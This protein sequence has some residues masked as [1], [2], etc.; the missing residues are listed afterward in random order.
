MYCE[1]RRGSLQAI[2]LLLLVPCASLSPIAAQKDAWKQA[3]TTKFEDVYVVTKFRPDLS[4]VEKPGTVL[5]MMREGVRGDL[6]SDESTS[7]TVVK[8]GQIKQ[9]GGMGGFLSDMGSAM[10][11]N[12]KE[13]SL[14]LQ[15]STR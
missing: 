4:G 3:L 5:V 6:V 14:Y 11:R 10:T 13:A 1:P 12:R 8:D 9:P 15:S 2:A 7:T